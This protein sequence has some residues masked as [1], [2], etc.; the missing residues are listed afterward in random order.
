MLEAYKAKKK[1]KIKIKKPKPCHY[2]KGNFCINEFLW[3]FYKW[4]ATAKKALSLTDLLSEGIESLGRLGKE[5]FPLRA[6]FPHSGSR[7]SY[8]ESYACKSRSILW[9][10]LFNGVHSVQ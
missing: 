5:K 9:S 3:A 8:V 4:G 1:M 10:L 6:G 2:Q 7:K